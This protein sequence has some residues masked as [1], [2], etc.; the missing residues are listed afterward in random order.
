M[1]HFN[2][3]SIGIVLDSWKKTALDD[4]VS[5]HLNNGHIGLY[6]NG[7]TP[8]QSITSLSQ[9]VECNFDTYSRLLLNA[10]TPSFVNAPGI[11]SVTPGVQHWLCPLAVL[12]VV[13]GYFILDRFN[14][15]VAV[16]QPFNSPIVFQLLNGDLYLTPYLS[17]GDAYLLQAL[18]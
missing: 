12:N 14:N 2:Y 10:W 5:T 17:W 1:A 8:S 6:Q 16:S 3:P 15:L 13:Y 11:V 4:L 7:V 18:P 9:L